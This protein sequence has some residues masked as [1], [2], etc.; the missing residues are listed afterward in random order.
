MELVITCTNKNSLELIPFKIIIY[1]NNCK[2]IIKKRTNYLKEK[3]VKNKIYYI[4]II[5]K[6]YI[7]KRTIYL[8]DNIKIN[9]IIPS[10]KKFILKDNL[11]IE[12][13][14]GKIILWQ[15]NMM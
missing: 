13:E 9:F 10:Y 7:I 11:G 3:L 6:N 4:E 2:K 14:R 12:I 15:E 1:S 8:N 5:V